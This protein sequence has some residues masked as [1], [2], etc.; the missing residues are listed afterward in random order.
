MT[1]RPLS[2]VVTAALA[3]ALGACQQQ[4]SKEETEAAK[5]TYA[6][7]YAGERLVIRFDSVLHE[8]RMLMPDGNMIALHQIPTASGVRFSNGTY[9]LTGKGTTLTLAR[10]GVAT[11]LDGCAN[12]PPPPKQ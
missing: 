5:N 2:I 1:R 8:A 4:P 9:E 6:C 3:C 11:P 7:D 10:F 12:L